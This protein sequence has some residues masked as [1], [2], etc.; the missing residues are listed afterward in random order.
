MCCEVTGVQRIRIIM[1]RGGQTL[2]DHMQKV[3]EGSSLKEELAPEKASDVDF[4]ASYRLVDPAKIETYARFFV[5]EDYD[6]MDGLINYKCCRNALRWIPNM[7]CVTERQ[8][9]YVFDALDVGYQSDISFR[10]FAVI[11]SLADRVTKMEDLLEVSNMTDIERKI[12]LYR[13]MFKCNTSS[14]R[15]KNYIKQEALRVELMAGGLHWDQQNFILEKIPANDYSEI[16]FLDYLCYI[17]LFLSF[18]DNITKNPL[19]MS[20]N[21]YTEEI[22]RRASIQRDMNPLGQSLSKDS[23][24]LK[25]YSSLDAANFADMLASKSTPKQ[26]SWANSR[27]KKEGSISSDDS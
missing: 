20:D 23:P 24:F 27:R 3:V 11:I 17:P 19:D 5:V 21:K 25:K 10:M 18:H 1:K 14:D 22:R 4:L 12:Q 9:D 26:P 6:N 7:K 15:D 13:N 8:L 2:L 16:S